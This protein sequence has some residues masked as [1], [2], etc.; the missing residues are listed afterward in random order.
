MR[1]YCSSDAAGPTSPIDW[2]ARQEQVSALP[3][4]AIEAAQDALNAERVGT[5]SHVVR[6]G[7]GPRTAGLSSR[8]VAE[9]LA[10]ARASVS[11]SGATDEHGG[12]VAILVY[13]ALPLGMT[14]L[15]CPECPAPVR[16]VP[17]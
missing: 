15:L 17:A 3:P 9:L 7:N 1:F 6:N 12:A 5:A 11:A 4:D 8:E 13:D 14:S 16:A 2:K 10:S